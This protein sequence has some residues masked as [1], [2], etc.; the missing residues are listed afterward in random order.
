METARSKCAG[1]KIATGVVDTE[2]SLSQGSKATKQDGGGEEMVGLET[3]PPWRS[4]TPILGPNPG[5]I[6]VECVDKCL[7]VCIVTELIETLS[8][9]VILL[10]HCALS[11]I[12]SAINRISSRVS[13][14]DAYWT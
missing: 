3:R 4:R 8:A 13:L 7:L 1:S 12:L 6:T 2:I 11:L 9:A 5:K 10:N 14:N